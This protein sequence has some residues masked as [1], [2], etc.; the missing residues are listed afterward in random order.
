MYIKLSGK[1]DS[2]QIIYSDNLSVQIYLC[3]F[4]FEAVICE[5]RLNLKTL[6][7]QQT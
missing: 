4:G 3:H 1:G 5:I 2:F 7:F 6:Y